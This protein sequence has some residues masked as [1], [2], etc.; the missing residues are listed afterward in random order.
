MPFGGVYT[1]LVEVLRV[2]KKME[3]GLKFIKLCKIFDYKST[4]LC[5]HYIPEHQ[6]FLY[7]C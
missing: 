7:P 5:S 2:T 1:E 4:G 6:T 3:Y